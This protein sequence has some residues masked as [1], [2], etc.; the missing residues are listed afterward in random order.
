MANCK[1]CESVGRPLSFDGYCFQCVEVCRKDLIINGIF[2]EREYQDA[3]WGTI[4]DHPHTVGEWLLIVER[5]LHEAKEAWVRK[6]GDK[7]ALRELLQVASTCFACMEQ[8]GVV[9]REATP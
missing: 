9:E 5:E 2:R 4:E 8:H 3:K 1:N 6:G 7:E